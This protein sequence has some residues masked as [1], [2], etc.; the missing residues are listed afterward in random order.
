MKQ[1][2]KTL[3]FVVGSMTKVYNWIRKQKEWE[4]KIENIKVNIL[5]PD[6]DP[7]DATVVAFTDGLALNGRQYGVVYAREGR[8]DERLTTALMQTRL[9]PWRTM[10]HF[11]S[12]LERHV[13]IVRRAARS[14]GVELPPPPSLIMHL[15]YLSADSILENEQKHKHYHRLINMPLDPSLRLS[16]LSARHLDQVWELRPSYF[17]DSYKPVIAAALTHNVS[18]G[19]LA[20]RPDNTEMLVSVVIQGEHGGLAIGRTH[21]DYRHRGLNLL[22]GMHVMRDMAQQGYSANG[23]TGTTNDIAIKFMETNSFQFVGKVMH[24]DISP[25]KSEIFE[26]KANL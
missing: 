13:E 11:S 16:H 12:V 21:P 2:W 26:N 8:G 20:L 22:V 7:N 19:I 3:L 4:E 17:S 14:A 23:T 9:V 6:G 25:E 18:Y 15:T 1:K 24:V 5:C 10:L